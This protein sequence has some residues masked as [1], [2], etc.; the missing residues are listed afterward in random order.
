VKD[1]EGIAEFLRAQRFEVIALYE[2]DAT[3]Q[4][5]I[6]AIE[7]RLAPKLTDQDRVLFFFA[8]H[9][10]TRTVDDKEHG[11]LVPYDGTEA[12]A[13]LVPLYQIR[14]LSDL[15]SRAKHQ[16]FILDACFGGLIAMRGSTVIREVD[17]RT[18]PNYIEEFTKRKARQVLT[19]GGA[20]QRVMD[21]GPG[22]HSLFTSELLKA[23]KEGLADRDR[24]GYITF[25]ELASY[26]QRAASQWNQTPGTV[27]L[28]G[29]QQGDFIFVNSNRTQTSQSG[30]ANTGPF[31]TAD[32][33][34]YNVLKAGKRFFLEKKYS[35]ALA[36]ISEAAEMG[37]PEAMT[38]L[39][40]M[41]WQGWGVR[42]DPDKALKW[43]HEA[44]DRGELVAMQNL[45]NIYLLPD[46]YQNPTEA[47]RWKATF[48]E[49]ER[50]MQF[51]LTL[52]TSGRQDVNEPTIPV[53]VLRVPPAAPTNLR[54][55]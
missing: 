53:D 32:S 44:A 9:G 3:R 21:S 5:I 55:E 24:D 49:A 41:Y 39:G 43:F 48:E 4:G 11:Y 35:A 18:N 25:T 17:L 19:A 42:V 29:H 54:V 30:S 52:D 51:V 50:Q 8:G 16:L 20:D 1:A 34:V 12:Y 14:D 36:P 7:D 13:S 47:M 27:D 26:M 31:R 22:G 6:A 15:M 45:M 33:D 28:P 10:I 38:I 40:K 37:N 2:K 23:L 46:R